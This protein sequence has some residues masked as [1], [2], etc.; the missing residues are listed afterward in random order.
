MKKSIKISIILILAIFPNILLGQNTLQDAV[1]HKNL[2]QKN[3]DDKQYNVSLINSRKALDIFVSLDEE[4]HEADCYLLRANTYLMKENPSFALQ[5]FLRAEETYKKI[6]DNSQLPYI[7]K[8][9]GLIYFKIK[10]YKKANEY[11]AKAL[12][13]TENEKD[14][15]EIF[16]YA[17]NSY[18]QS[19]KYDSALVCF[20]EMKKI[21]DKNDNN[22]LKIKSLQ[23]IVETNKKQKNYSEAIDNN[24]KIYDIYY[25]DENLQGLAQ[26]LNN[27]GFNNVIIKQYENAI[28]AFSE[29]II[30]QKKAK[31]PETY[32]AKTYTNIGICYQNQQDIENAIK[33]YLKAEEIWKTE[34]NPNELAK[35]Q[36]IIAITYYQFGDL[37]NAATFSEESVVN[38]DKSSNLETK[39]NC[40]HTYSIILQAGNDFQN[41]LEF[42]KKHLAVRDSLIRIDDAKNQEL[43]RKIHELEKSEE[44][45]KLKLAEEEIQD[46]LL[47][48]LKLENEKKEKENEL[49]RQKQELQD[50]E[51]LQKQYAL[52]MERQR[53]EAIKKQQEIEALENEQKIKDL[54][55]QQKEADAQK[56][57]KEIEL[58]ETEKEKQQ[59]EIDKNEATRKFFRWVTV[60]FAAIFVLIMIFLFFSIRANRRLNKQ[61]VKILEQNAKLSSQK[62]EIQ[63]QA[64]E[65]QAVN[66][67][68]T[69]HKN[70]LEEKH[71]QITDS[72]TY[73]SRI[74]GAMLPD[75]RELASF[76]KNHFIVYKPRDIVS[77][78]FYWIKEVSINNSPQLLVAAADCTGHGV[79]GAFVSMLGMSLLNEIVNKQNDLPVGEILN[80][81][82]DEIKTS[83]KQYG[84]SASKDGMDIA[85]CRI[86]KENNTLQFAGAHN[87][88][89]FVG[90]NQPEILSETKPKKIRVFNPNDK[91]GILTEIKSDHQPIGV[92]IKERPFENV[93][94]K[95]EKGNRIYIFSDGFIDQ[96]GGE[97]NEKYKSKNFKQKIV[98]M[99][100]SPINKHSQILENEFERWTTSYKT[101]NQLDD[102]LIIGIEI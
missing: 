47:E 50:A 54:E 42:Y 74:Q 32:S 71:Q 86:D 65:L 51:L 18:F 49:L 6:S 99:Q 29:A 22:S 15:F 79:P 91:N 76:F 66:E 46:I 69:Y 41:A 55:L 25:A 82:R 9:I 39:K 73:A 36:N 33:N 40:Y 63:S 37:H 58:L 12:L 2:S 16:E 31:M 56:R 53:H 13:S 64:D 30:F 11:F 23:K 35:I 28:K 81:L 102:I 52:E 87:P 17:G 90:N 78:D 5:N 45:L 4:K 70:N 94:L 14:K 8:Q 27:I 80:Q 100:S 60:L 34:N 92:Y 95:V 88:L 89:Y 20:S 48:Q 19:Q 57:Q 98:E 62:E 97:K 83:L 93:E 10:A 68:I 96:F 3:F 1:Y 7:Y 84:E 26:V 75:S 38:A 59:L 43:N 67:E 61:K 44:D 77:G 72:I 21:A 85:M 101:Y 24:F